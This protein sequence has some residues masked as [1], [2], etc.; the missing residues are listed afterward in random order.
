[1]MRNEPIINQQL[2]SERQEL[3]AFYNRLDANQRNKWQNY[4]QELT[5]RDFQEAK[6]VQELNSLSEQH[7]RQLIA[8]TKLL[9][10]A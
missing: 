8:Y 4:W 9:L 6:M 7:Y 1:M 3:L 5:K 2:R 10:W